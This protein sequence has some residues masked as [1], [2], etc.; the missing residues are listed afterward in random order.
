VFG[1][2]FWKP[3]NIPFPAIDVAVLFWAPHALNLDNASFAFSWATVAVG[4]GG[5]LQLCESWSRWAKQYCFQQET[6]FTP[7]CIGVFTIV[8]HFS[9][10]QGASR[11][12]RTLEEVGADCVAFGR[13]EESQDPAFLQECAVSVRWSRQNVLRPA[14]ALRVRVSNHSSSTSGGGKE[15]GKDRIP[16]TGFTEERQEVELLASVDIAVRADSSYIGV[17]EDFLTIST[18]C[19][20]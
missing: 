20:H 17:L 7:G 13:S 5:G 1:G 18:G 2:F 11:R 14:T 9:A 4:A 10:A 19:R 12:F 3:E 8:L 15:K 6:Q 16:F